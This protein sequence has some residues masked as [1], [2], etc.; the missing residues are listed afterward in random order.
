MK[1]KA[2][3]VHERLCQAYQ[4]PIAYFHSF[5]PLS[6]LVSSLL[7]H[8]TRNRDSGTAFKQLRARFPIWEE[9]E[10][11]PTAEVQEAI[12]AVTWP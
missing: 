5:D 6:E 10:A 11:A 9:V 12:S 4:C 2:L 7:S 3:L 1:E 8:R